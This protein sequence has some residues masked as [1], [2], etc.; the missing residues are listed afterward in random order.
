VQEKPAA[1][2]FRSELR[3]TFIS[4]EA[5]YRVYRR[6]AERYHSCAERD[7]EVALNLLLV[8]SGE[9]DALVGSETVSPTVEPEQTQGRLTTRERQIL[10]LIAAGNSTKQ[11][12]AALGI[13]FKTAVGHRSQLM[14]K[15]NIHDTASLV[16]Y[17]IR[18][19]FIEP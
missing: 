1:E 16:R 15:L 10:R 3:S 14:K 13:T 2:P 9:R 8:A 19:G 4:L 6:A 18:A 12:A 11:A 7:L 17:A 5:E